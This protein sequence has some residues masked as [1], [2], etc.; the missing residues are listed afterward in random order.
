[1]VHPPG[2]L[3]SGTDYRSFRRAGL[4]FGIANGQG[5]TW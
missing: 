1:V 3:A 4:R 5:T 2:S